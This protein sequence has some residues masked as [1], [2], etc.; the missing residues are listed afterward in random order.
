[1]KEM[2]KICS[3]MIKLKHSKLKYE[4]RRKSYQFQLISWKLGDFNSIVS[5]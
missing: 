3:K 5:Y 4:N 1:M 2:N